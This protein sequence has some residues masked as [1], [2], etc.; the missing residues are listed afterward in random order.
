MDRKLFQ[1]PTSAYRPIPFWSWNDHLEPKRIREQV[2]HMHAIGL[3]GFFMHSRQGLATPFMGHDWMEAVAAA[4]NEAGRLGMEAWIYDEDR[5]P[6]GPAGGLALERNVTAFTAK[7]LCFTD[8]DTIESVPGTLLARFAYEAHSEGVCEVRH[9]EANAGLGPKERCL[10]FFWQNAKP[11]GWFNGFSYLDTLDADAVQSFIVHGLEPYKER[12]ASHFGHEIPGVFTDEPQ[13][14]AERRGQ[15][16]TLP[17][18]TRFPVEFRQRCGYDIIPNLASLVLATEDA[19]QIRYD[20]WRT[21][22]QL[23]L[24]NWC[25]P[26]AN[27]C[28]QNGLLWTGHYWEHEFPYFY[29]AGSF[30]AP[31]AYLHVPGVDLL[32]GRDYAGKLPGDAIQ[33]QMGNVQMI[34]LASSVAHQMGRE[35]LLSETYGGAMSDLSFQDQKIMGDWQYALG[36]NLLNQHL[37]HYSLRGLRKRDYPPSWGEHQPWAKE[38]DYL[39]DYFGRLSYA[40]TRGDYVADIAVL[41]PITVFWVE[42]FNRQ[43]IA[44]AFEDLCKDLTEANWD[45]DLA[46][47]VLME[48]SANTKGNKLCIGQ[49]LYSVFV[50]PPSTVLATSTLDIVEK[51]IEAGST[52][53]YM[54]ESPRA[55]QVSDNERLARLLPFMDAARDFASLEHILQSK[56]KRTVTIHPRHAGATEPSAQTDQ[57]LPRIYTHSRRIDNSLMVFLAN[58]GEA[59][60]LEAEVI[61]NHH[62]PLAWLDLFT[63]E[64]KPISYRK[65]AEG[66]ATNLRFLEAESHLLVAGALTK[67]WCLDEK[68]PYKIIQSPYEDAK[69]IPLRDWIV[70]PQEDNTLVLDW[71]RYRIDGSKWSLP[72]PIWDAYTRIRQAYGLS[73]SRANRD[74]Q[75][76]RQMQD[77]RPITSSEIIEIELTFNVGNLAKRSARPVRLVVESGESY[78]INVNGYS[79]PHLAGTWLDEAF[80]AFDITNSLREG[81]N[82]ILLS[83]TFS[84]LWELENS[85]LLGD[86]HVTPTAIG[87]PSAVDFQTN[88]VKLGDWTKQ[89]YP[90][91]AGQMEYMTTFNWEG[92]QGTPILEL[93]GLKAPIAAICLNGENLGR[94]AIPPYTLCLTKGIEKG[95]NHLRIVVTNSL[96]NLLDPLH[97]LE[98]P[99]IAGPEVF[100]D[101]SN[102]QDEYNLVPQGLGDVR[103][104]I[105]K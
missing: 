9:L 82:T 24:E 95:E 21:A 100:S 39:A 67:D 45:Y 30:M 14:Y 63:G 73:T 38:Y 59:S 105:A 84:E 102:W 54:G 50:L 23:L 31:L 103:L 17:W 10:T 72:I 98:V 2:R 57:P 101:P 5:Y 61:I 81:P 29:K 37:Y 44:R 87:R 69:A 96:R 19:W 8:E 15:T 46:D 104:V 3:G 58:V 40:M 64:I 89:G 74:V 6:S 48:T 51:L 34:K 43:D 53:A 76:W 65:T 1:N 18:T 47:E 60:C 91:Y 22:T 86:F 78:T 97:H 13:I 7:H 56:A 32:G 11:S 27:W 28:D 52:V 88:T 68:R 25:E 20:F 16:S 85:F 62:G 83:T 12:F 42:G 35:R 33:S 26:V 80:T 55:V 71:C 90:F 41:H 99:F 94:I 4:V 75:P 36:V 92:D 49:G 93:V 77:R 79:R 70:R 66:I